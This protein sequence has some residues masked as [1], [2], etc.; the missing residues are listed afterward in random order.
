[1]WEGERG[2][3]SPSSKTADQAPFEHGTR[4]FKPS[5]NRHWPLMEDGGEVSFAVFWNLKPDI[6]QQQHTSEAKRTQ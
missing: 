4:A 5:R 1:M 2:T 6:A 3:C